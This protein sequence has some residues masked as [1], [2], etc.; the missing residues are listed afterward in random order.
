MTLNATTTE[1]IDAVSPTTEH[2]DDAGVNVAKTH[3]DRQTRF[4]VLNRS[5]LQQLCYKV[6]GNLRQ[7]RGQPSHFKVTDVAISNE[8]RPSANDMRSDTQSI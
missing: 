1:R 7:S 3:T 5:F 6:S 2:I 4:E 8:A